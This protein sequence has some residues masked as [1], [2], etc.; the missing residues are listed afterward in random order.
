MCL[1]LNLNFLIKSFII[2]LLTK[3]IINILIKTSFF[4]KYAIEKINAL[5]KIC[6]LEESNDKALSLIKLEN[7]KAGDLSIRFLSLKN[8]SLEFSNIGGCYAGFF[9][10]NCF[11][12]TNFFCNISVDYCPISF[13]VLNSSIVFDNEA[14]KTI[15]EKLIN[16]PSESKK[17]LI[18]AYL[19]NFFKKMMLE[20]QIEMSLYAKKHIY[21]FFIIEMYAYIYDKII[22]SVNFEV[23]FEKILKK[24]KSLIIDLL[25]IIHNNLLKNE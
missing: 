9:G 16:E 24:V 7:F 20:F 23:I 4:K 19:E 13:N 15:W 25:T 6:E 8:I 3:Q 18:I 10:K 5:K 14:K 22:Q 21:I 11:N 1:K 12:K 17:S 2:F